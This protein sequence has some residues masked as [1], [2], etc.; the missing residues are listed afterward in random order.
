[1]VCFLFMVFFITHMAYEIVFKNFSQHALEFTMWKWNGLKLIEIGSV[2]I[3]L[4]IK[5]DK[6]KDYKWKWYVLNLLF[7]V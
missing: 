3:N 1:M 7:G 4:C 6:I 2:L 5:R